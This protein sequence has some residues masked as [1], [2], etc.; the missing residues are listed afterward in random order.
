[1][2][3]ERERTWLRGLTAG[4]GT[5]T[6]MKFAATDALSAAVMR[7][8]LRRMIVILCIRSCCVVLLSM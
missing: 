7:A 8:M 4:R 6:M 5:V 1:M 2:R 3:A